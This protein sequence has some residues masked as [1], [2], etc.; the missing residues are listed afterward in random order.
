MIADYAHHPDEIEAALS[1]AREITDEITVVFQ[2]HTYS[3]T[4]FLKDKFIGVLKSVPDLILYRT[5]A[6]REN[7][8]AGGGAY[9]L[10]KDIGGETEYCED[11]ETLLKIL[12]K[13]AVKGGI[14]LIL[15]AGDLY[16]ELKTRLL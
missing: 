13:R 2:P 5:Y 15:G 9:D 11:A 8:M 6:A 7:Y 14:I 10:Y 16:D 3:R 4:L 1:T 12:G